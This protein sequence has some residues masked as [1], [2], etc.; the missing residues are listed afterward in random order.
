MFIVKMSILLK[1]SHRVNII[2]AKIPT[3]LLVE[4]DRLILNFI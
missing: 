2:L 4:T 3:G 1:L